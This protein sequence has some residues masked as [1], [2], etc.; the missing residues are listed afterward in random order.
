MIETYTERFSALIAMA[1]PGQIE[2]ASTWYVDAENVAR[3]VAEN[4]NATVEVGASVISAFS[5]RERWT[6]NVAKAVAFSL[7]HD[8]RGLPNNLAMANSALVNGFDA[9]RGPKTNAFARAIAGDESAVV[10]DIWMM[11]AAKVDSDAPNK[12]QYREM[13]EAIANIAGKTGMTNRTVQA[14]IWI[15]VRGSA[16]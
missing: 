1:T 14:L 9:L 13:T 12:T 7:G 15:L 10:I 16:E 4:L 6:T 5:P 11:R 3:E 8:V 2:Q